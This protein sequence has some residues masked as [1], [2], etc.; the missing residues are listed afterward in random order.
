LKLHERLQLGWRWQ[1]EGGGAGGASEDEEA[2]K[3]LASALYGTFRL[4]ESVADALRAAL[5]KEQQHA[6]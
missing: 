4:G 1:W 3:L 2:A 5:Y 6:G